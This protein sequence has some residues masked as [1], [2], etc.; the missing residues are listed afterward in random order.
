MALVDGYS[1]DPRELLD[2]VKVRDF[3]RW[4]NIKLA[5]EQAFEVSPLRQ[6]LGFDGP[7]AQQTYY[8][9]RRD[10]TYKTRRH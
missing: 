6:A 8:Q 3:L 4:L 1:D 7:V 2:I 9:A 5:W 10:T